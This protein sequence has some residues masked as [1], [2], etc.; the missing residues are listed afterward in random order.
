MVGYHD[1]VSGLPNKK[2][3][4]YITS[5]LAA[6]SVFGHCKC[7]GNHQHQPLEGANE[8][9]P[10]TAHAAAWPSQLIIQQALMEEEIAINVHETYPTESS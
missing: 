1:K 9:G 3:S 10:R 7:D 6:E 4:F 5:L 2:P 8:L